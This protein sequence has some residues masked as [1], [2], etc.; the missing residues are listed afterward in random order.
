MVGKVWWILCLLKS[1]SQK[2]LVEQN[3]SL[4]YRPFLDIVQYYLVSKMYAVLVFLNKLFLN[5]Q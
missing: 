1:L 5:K 2:Q 4:G 3:Y